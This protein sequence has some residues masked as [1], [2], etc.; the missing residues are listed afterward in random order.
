MSVYLIVIILWII[1]AV[2][3][4]KNFRSHIEKDGRIRHPLQSW[5]NLLVVIIVA[6]CMTYIRDK[7]DICEGHFTTA[8]VISIA[9]YYRYG[10]KLYSV[11]FDNGIVEIGISDIDL[12][13]VGSVGFFDCDKV[14]LK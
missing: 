12:Y 8:R 11:S 5:K 9:P 3:I 1:G 13:P 2:I 14:L 4:A 6:M 7:K 10:V